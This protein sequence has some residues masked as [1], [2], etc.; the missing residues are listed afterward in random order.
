MP[1]VYLLEFI[2]AVFVVIIFVNQLIVPIAK[3]LPIFPFF[4]KT[5]KLSEELTTVNGA[6]EDLKLEQKISKRKR[7][8]KETKKKG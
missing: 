1:T 5:R 2:F 6:I 3:G 8:I 4:R 7:F